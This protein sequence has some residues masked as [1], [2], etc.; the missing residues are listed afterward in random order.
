MLAGIVFVFFGKGGT[1]PGEA[2]NSK[3]LRT[4]LIE[5]SFWVMIALFTLGIG[6]SFGV[7]TMMPLFLVAEKGMDRA[8]ANTLVA[9]SR[10]PTL[11]VS[12][13]A[14]WVADRFGPK[15]TLRGVF[16]ATGMATLLLGLVPGSW[17]GLLVLLQSVLATSFFPA[18]FAILS[19]MGSTSIKNVAV[20]LTVPIGMLLGGGAIV[21]GIGIF[22]EMGA[23]S[24]GIALFGG[25]IFGG[26]ILV[27]YLKFADDP[28]QT[29]RNLSSLP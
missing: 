15:Q 12:I 1:F 2:P 19:R 3:I 16:M 11:G 17:I 20:S 26:V 21:A 5:P 24:V 14:G 23:F 8:W 9:I 28:I 25:L 18:G 22:G 10:I 13:L 4:I 29:T 6:A 27:R 7:Y